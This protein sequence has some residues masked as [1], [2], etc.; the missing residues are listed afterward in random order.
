MPL[1][2]VGRDRIAGL[3]TGSETCHWG[4]SGATIFVVNGTGTAFSA[5]SSWPLT[6]AVGATGESGF[7]LTAAN[8]FQHRG[9]FSTA[10]ANFAWDNWWIHTATASGSGVPLNWASTQALGTKTSAQSWQIT[11]SVTVTT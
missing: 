2:R 11:T 3:I 5:A 7:P 4:T 10:Q 8:I 9:I 6:G 1:L